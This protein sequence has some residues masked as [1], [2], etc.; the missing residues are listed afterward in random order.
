MSVTG[1]R[2]LHV[3]G[4]R[5]RRWLAFLAA[6]APPAAIAL[7][8]L[9]LLPII[10]L[11]V[12]VAVAED[13]AGYADALILYVVLLVTFLAGI[14]WG[15]AMRADAARSEGLA[16]TV[17][18]PLA[19]GAALFIPQAVA[20]GLLAAILAAQGAWDVWS[21]ER[22]RLPFWFGRLRARTTPVAVVAMVAAV[23]LL[24]AEAG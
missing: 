12:L 6:G 21:A 10:V 3:D 24:A 7:S 19:A 5:R 8:Y 18:A 17:V 13:R 20:A 23:I 9:S 2:E 16:L 1:G 11:V 4:A 15:H 22:G 14:R